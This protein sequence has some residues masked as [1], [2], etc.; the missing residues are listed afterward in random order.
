MNWQLFSIFWA[1]RFDGIIVAILLHL[2]FTDKWL[3]V[4]LDI[5]DT[6]CSRCMLWARCGRLGWEV[7]CHLWD[8][9]PLIS[10]ITFSFLSASSVMVRD[11]S[12]GQILVTQRLSSLYLLYPDDTISDLRL[13]WILV[14][15]E[16]LNLL[17]RGLILHGRVGKH[18]TMSWLQRAPELLAATRMLGLQEARVMLLQACKIAALAGIFFF[19]SW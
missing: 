5:G 8:S 14:N 17:G 13:A 11:L 19:N 2:L 15:A 3:V 7:A 4:Y 12:L 6:C 10:I 16:G 9:N 18:L 1:E